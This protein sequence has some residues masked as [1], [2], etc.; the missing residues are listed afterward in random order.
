MP[1]YEVRDWI[2]VH[3]IQRR[4]LDIA[5]SLGFSRRESNELAIV[6]SELTS[7]ILK[8]GVRGTI[9]VEAYADEKGNGISIVARDYGPAFHDL[10]TALLDGHD[11]KGPIDPLHMLK[12]KG[13]GGGL[14]AVLRLTHS[15]RVEPER[16]GKRVHVV[17]YLSARSRRPPRR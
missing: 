4:T 8:Y 9:D 14:G 5:N 1:T 10:E 17:R 3:H 12:R 6:A 7:N 15:F 2:D 13:I 11:D 16:V